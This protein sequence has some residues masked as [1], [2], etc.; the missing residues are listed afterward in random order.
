MRTRI[1][2]IK[3]LVG[4]DT[5]HKLRLQG[6]EMMELGQVEN[7]WLL[8]E[9]GHIADWG[10]MEE[11]GLLP[12]AP[13][14][15]E[16]DAGGGMVLPCWCDPH[17][18]IVYA[19]SREGEFVDKIQGLSYAEIARRG[20]GILN[21]A[22][23]LHAA[24]EEELYRQATERAWEMIAKGTGCIEIKSGYGL[25][26]A[27]ELKMLRV[28][29][30]MKESL[31]VRIVSTFLGAHAVG[32]GYS[33]PEYVDLVVREMIPE[34]GRQGLADYIDVF[35]DKGFF[36]PEE[37]ARMLEAG[38]KWGLM[39]KIHADELASSGGVVVG[40]AHH[41]RSV[42]HLECMAD[43][44]IETLRG[45]D[46]MPTLLPGTSFFLNMPFGPARRMVDAGLGVAV[47]SDY[48]PGSTPSG[49]M[50]FV[51]S[52]ACIKLRLLPAE[53]LNA[54]TLN[55]AYAMGLSQEYGSIAVGKVANFFLTKP[56]PSVDF[57]PYAYT[58]PIIRQVFLRGK[59]WNLSEAQTSFPSVQTSFP[60]SKPQI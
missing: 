47:A 32:R 18:H 15:E 53:A 4:V 14:D 41:A 27:D 35:C 13:V 31:P 30:R 5:H 50:K 51:V 56:I 44:Q 12:P 28:I 37:T 48:N 19:G 38:A 43:A 8:V 54:A 59:A 20:G 26:T 49:D 60:S 17:T 9:D 36:T 7:A 57:I 16:V 42:D 45:S 23:R 6:K 29:R 25:N 46:T 11:L 55:A 3:R 33:Q 21:S 2:N 52:L 1:V 22:D 40:V 34:V 58:T 24:S 39:P 10:T